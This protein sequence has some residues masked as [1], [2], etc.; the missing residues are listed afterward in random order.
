LN[1]RILN[2][3]S[4]LLLAILAG[5]GSDT[6]PA[7]RPAM[8]QAPLP[9]IIPAPSEFAVAAGSFHI[10]ATTPV[11]YSGGAGAQ[12]AATYFVELANQFLATPL[13][14]A[15][16][17]AEGSKAISFL[18]ANDEKAFPPEGYSL[19]VAPDGARITARTP[20]GLLYGAVTLWQLTT[21]YSQLGGL[22]TLPALKVTDAP[23]FAWRG[24]M[25]DSARHYQSP[26]FIMKFIDWMALHKLNVLHWH[27]RRPGMAAGDKI[28]PPHFPSAPGRAGGPR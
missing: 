25:L 1:H 27:H 3:A 13:N 9:S 28:S 2:V 19:V 7:S 26:E 4:G 8:P 17:G 11:T 10:D 22:V 18:L 24:L 16:E 6:A 14:G 23:R 12:A 5:C 20:A 21:A 15:R